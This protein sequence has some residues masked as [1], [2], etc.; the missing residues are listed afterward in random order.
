MKK[1]IANAYR[2][3]SLVSRIRLSYIIPF[4]P[5]ILLYIFSYY[6]FWDSYQKYGAMINSVVKASAF[7]MDFKHDFDNATYLLIVG[8]EDEETSSLGT[9][10]DDAGKVVSELESIT[11][12]TENIERLKDIKNYLNNLETYLN[13]IKENLSVEGTYDQNMQIWE[14]DVQVGT[15]L[16]QES[17]YRYIF[18]E[19]RELDQERANQ[20]DNF[21]GVLSVSIV[22]YIIVVILILIISYYFNRLLRQVRNEQVQLRK[23]ELMVLQSQINP[24]FLY[25]TLDA[26]TWLA[27]AGEQETVVKMVG[28]LSGF[29][30]TSLNQG[31]DIVTLAEELQHIRSYLEIQKIRYQDILEYNIDVSDEFGD[32]QIPKITLQPLVENAIYHGIK[33]KRGGGTITVTG[34]RDGDDLRISVRDD[35]VGMEEERLRAVLDGIFEKKPEEKDIYGLYNVNERIRLYFGDDYGIT[36]ISEKGVG[37]ESVVRLPI[38]VQTSL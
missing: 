19:V 35:G 37:T 9:M 36:L 26:I 1:K 33:N 25:N 30:R 23:A 6:N 22:A 32:V 8:Q 24:H 11:K 2:H 21:K 12:N 31:K 17:V 34:K 4:V 14:N 20:Q 28:S 15:A 5:V 29:F 27:E 38:S 13:H 3:L 10:L 18:Y 7:N 16:L